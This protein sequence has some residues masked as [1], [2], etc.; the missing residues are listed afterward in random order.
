MTDV[1]PGV[2]TNRFQGKVRR[3]PEKGRGTEIEFLDIDDINT[4]AIRKEEFYP[5]VTKTSCIPLENPDRVRRRNRKR[6]KSSGSEK[7]SE[8]LGT[9]VRV[10]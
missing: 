6:I 8:E 2:G 5:Y 7:D 10:K 1:R 3:D 9:E 4:R